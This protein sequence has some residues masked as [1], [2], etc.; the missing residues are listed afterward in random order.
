MR[1]FMCEFVTGG[2]LRGEELPDSLA[3]EGALM[4]DALAR[5]LRELGVEVCATFDDRA[6]SVE[7]AENV[8]VREGDD[9]WPLWF[10]LSRAAD[11][12]FPIAPETRE[13]VERFARLR[14]VSEVRLIGPDAE[15]VRVA[16]SKRL[17]ADRLRAAGVPV[18]EVWAPDDLP[19]DFSGP[20]VSKP[21]DGAGCED[22]LLW[23]APPP[24]GALP[25]GHVVQAYVPGEPISLTVLTTPA[26]TR[27]L[28]VN[29]QHVVIENGRFTFRGLSVGA[30]DDPDGR[31]AALAE[32]AARA[33]PGLSGIY[34]I[35]AVL[36]A[37][38]PVVIEINPR[39]T[40]AYA[41]LREALGFNPLTLLPEFAPEHP[42]PHAPARRSVEIAL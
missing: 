2:G 1:V 11:A 24:A 39:L 31:L 20:L 23:D 34:G 5:D 3:R 25:A 6:R 4:R 14:E 7:G 36:G 10:E 21:D 16:A 26:G 8:P 35:D 28:A 32:G 33:L 42:A 29:R 9:P 12:V 40:T 19:P 27:L 38:G 13:V 41:G 37:E 15:A 22:T 17:T 30:L 18:A